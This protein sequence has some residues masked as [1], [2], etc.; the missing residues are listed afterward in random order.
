VGVEKNDSAINVG[1]WANAVKSTLDTPRSTP[2]RRDSFIDRWA[3]IRLSAPKKS[4][5]ARQISVF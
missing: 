1:L 2:E 4:G 3:D 5:S